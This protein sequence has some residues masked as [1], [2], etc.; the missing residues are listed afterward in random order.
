MLIDVGSIIKYAAASIHRELPRY[1]AL[2]AVGL[3]DDSC[4]YLVGI[5]TA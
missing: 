1:F 5:N 3:S 2:C 4:Y